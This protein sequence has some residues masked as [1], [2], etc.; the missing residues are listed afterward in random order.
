MNETHRLGRSIVSVLRVLHDKY[1]NLRSVA[2]TETEFRVWN[3]PRSLACKKRLRLQSL[4][5][6]VLA[7]QQTLNQNGV[8]D[9]CLVCFLV[10]TSI[11]MSIKTC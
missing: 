1:R 2:E 5:R 8:L 4:G 10:S 7:D 3:M 11:F 6:E 9:F